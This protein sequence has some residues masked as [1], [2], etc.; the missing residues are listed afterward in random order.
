[1]SGY[2]LYRHVTSEPKSYDEIIAIVCDNGSRRN[3]DIYGWDA[4]WFERCERGYFMVSFEGQDIPNA[5]LDSD[6]TV[7]GRCGG[8]PLPFPL[9][10]LSYPECVFLESLEC[11]Y[12]TAYYCK[13]SSQG[14]SPI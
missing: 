13:N 10:E 4:Q 1:M 3:E 5:Y 7:R 2:I 8:L 6:G 14:D 9:D 12:S 11:D